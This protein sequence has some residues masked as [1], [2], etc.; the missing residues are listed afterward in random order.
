MTHLFDGILGPQQQALNVH[1]RR[2]ELLSANIANADTPGYKA[3]DIDFRAALARATES[4]TV[5][6][7]TDPNHLS[8][9]SAAAGQGDPLYRVPLQPSLDGNTVNT[10]VEKQAFAEASVR[11]E[12]A[13][14]FL[15]RRIS[16]LKSALRSE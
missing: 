7:R 6:T 12:S 8:L 2:L 4:T 13:L 3:R 15:N 10:Q 9:G 11:Y 16:G 1:G 14:D 5:A